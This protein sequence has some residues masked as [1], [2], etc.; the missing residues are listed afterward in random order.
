MTQIA[1]ISYYPVETSPTIIS[2]CEYLSERGYQV[3]LI[4][5]TLWRDKSFNIPNVKIRK[6]LPGYMSNSV[7]RELTNRLGKLSCFAH[8]YC[9]NRLKEIINNYD[10]IFCIEFSSLD[11]VAKTDYDLSK[12]IYFSL[13]GI[14]CTRPFKINY[15]KEA[16]S[17]CAFSIIASKERGND[18]EKHF[19]MSIDFEYVPVSLRPPRDAQKFIDKTQT[20]KNEIKFIQSGY[21]AEWTCLSEFIDAYKGMNNINGDSKVY[22]HGHKIGTDKYYKTILSQV[23]D[24]HNVHIDLSYYSSTQHL[25]F[26]SQFDIGLAFY[27]NYINS[28]DWENLIFSSGKIASYLWAGLAVLTNILHPHTKNP[29]FLYVDS[30]SVDSLSAAISEYSDNRSVYKVAAINH[31]KKYYNIDHYMIKVERRFDSI[32]G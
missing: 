2:I 18:L 19:N 17:R 14:A 27:K 25:K 5:D 11:A 12:V 15:V 3:D 7:W 29:P 20:T 30:I 26:L 31:A 21:F 6:L 23:K 22:L 9:T 10:I 16:I 1:I 24:M 28:T 8:R 32:I 4:V 13:E